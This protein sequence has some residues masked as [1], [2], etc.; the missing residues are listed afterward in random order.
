M[1]R[2]VIK[3]MYPTFDPEQPVNYYPL[4]VINRHKNPAHIGKNM[5]LYAQE[6][7]VD[8]LEL[9]MDLFAED[10]DMCANVSM[11]GFAEANDILSRHPMAMPCAD[12]MCCSKDTNFNFSDEI[13]LNPNPMTL[14]F[15]P[16][17]ILVHGK[18]RFEDTIRQISGFVAERFRIP[19]RGFLKE[20]YFADIVVL[21]REKLKSYDMDE[22]P[23][24]YPD[25]FEHVIVNGVPT[26]ENKRHLDAKAGRMLR[27]I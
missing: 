13:P 27:K 18:P 3:E 24:Q 20:G 8:A 11:A 14:S 12:G 1:V 15:I 26:I 5:A 16:R 10:P 17:Y 25:G 4:F 6:L 19:K 21:D 2:L 23:L 9:M 22:N 7:G